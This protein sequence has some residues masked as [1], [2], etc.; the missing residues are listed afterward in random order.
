MSGSKGDPGQFAGAC[1]CVSCVYVFSLRQYTCESYLRQLMSEH[2]L[3]ITPI[4]TLTN[5]SILHSLIKNRCKRHFHRA[6][7]KEWETARGNPSSLSQ[8]ISIYVEIR[9]LLVTLLLSFGLEGKRVTE[10]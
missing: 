10:Q 5:E 4:N 2:N 6:L 1:V 7:F 3:F 8:L 9:G